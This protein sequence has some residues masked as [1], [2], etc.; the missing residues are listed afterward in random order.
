MCLDNGIFLKETVVLG[1]VDMYEN[2]FMF[3]GFNLDLLNTF[4]FFSDNVAVLEKDEL[5]R[6][7]FSEKIGNGTI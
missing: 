7:E 4:R 2:R 1:D 3:I 6:I 5:L